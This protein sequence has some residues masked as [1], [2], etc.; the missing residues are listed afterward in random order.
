M[1]RGPGLKSGHVPSVTTL[2][3]EATAESFPVQDGSS[4]HARTIQR[5]VDAVVAVD[6]SCALEDC[7]RGSAAN[8]AAA[9]GVVPSRVAALRSGE[10]ALTV[11]KVA[12]MPAEVRAAFYARHFSRLGFAWFD[13]LSRA[14]LAQRSVA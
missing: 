3:E 10:S 5:S 13:G 8:V 12:R 9:L 4:D 2:T 1:N 7:G 11:G 6:F 14:V